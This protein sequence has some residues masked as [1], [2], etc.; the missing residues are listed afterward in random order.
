[1]VKSFLGHYEMPKAKRPPIEFFYVDR[2]E[3]EPE[4]WYQCWRSEYGG[5]LA[6]RREAIA[7][8]EWNGRGVAFIGEP[9]WMK[10][11]RIA[12]RVGWLCIIASLAIV[13]YELVL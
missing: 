6:S 3:H 4:F 12:G 13:V 5:S 8:G 1:M 9:A 10:R 2:I 11:K 7:D